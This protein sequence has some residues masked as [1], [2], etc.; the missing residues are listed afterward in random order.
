MGPR[1]PHPTNSNVPSSAASKPPLAASRMCSMCALHPSAPGR[2]RP[3]TRSSNCG[4]NTFAAG[5]WLCLLP[6]PL[7]EGK[8]RSI[9]IRLSQAYRCI[10]SGSTPF[11]GAREG[12]LHWFT[13]G[14]GGDNRQLQ[15][16]LTIRLQTLTTHFGTA[17][18]RQCLDHRLWDCLH[19]SSTVTALP[20]LLHGVCFVSKA[21]T[22]K[23]LPVVDHG[24]IAGNLL[25]TGLFHDFRGLR[26]TGAQI[27]R[28]MHIV[29][30][31]AGGLSALADVLDG[32]REIVECCPVHQHTVSHGASE[33]QHLRT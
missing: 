30:R 3:G 18:N 12:L 11:D 19:G 13:N 28:N 16:S 31:A 26:D 25:T 21:N 5:C 29:E 24:A 7:G 4:A 15:A 10:V 1:S 14:K 27:R 8:E 20:G 22:G 32:L 17:V 2:I 9:K 6:L 23:V 33:P